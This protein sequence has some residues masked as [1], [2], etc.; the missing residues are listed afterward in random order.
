MLT[1]G[2][3]KEK[4]ET[5]IQSI[6]GIVRDNK[7]DALRAVNN[8][9]KKAYW[10]IGHY[11]AKFKTSGKYGAGQS[12]K[13]NADI[14]NALSVKYNEISGRFFLA[15]LEKYYNKYPEWEDVPP[16]LFWGHL[17]LLLS[18]EDEKEYEFYANL[19]IHNGWTHRDLRKNLKNSYY[20]QVVISGK[21][22][23]KV[24]KYKLETVLKDYHTEKFLGLIDKPKTTGYDIKAGLMRNI[25]KLLMESD[26][27]F[28]LAGQNFQVNIYNDTKMLDY[29]YY[30]RF[31]KC[32]I[33]M[34][35]TIGDISYQD[36][37]Q[38]NLVLS[39]FSKEMNSEG[40]NLP[41]GI[42]LGAQKDEL[43][44]EF[45]IGELR[46]SKFYEN[47]HRYLPTKP[48]SMKI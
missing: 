27:G 6:E 33:I 37:A 9:I 25:N 16:A 19:C 44:L 8:N 17:E 3:N 40:D 23:E 42:I 28:C 26:N 18:I 46:K 48:F 1:S 5:L 4:F 24:K 39:H 31:L 32:F 38:M 12:A 7:T 43:L 20:Q 36:I 29:V 2:V 10:E 21:H 14:S 11:I 15:L 41:I 34:K 47:Y 35:L 13:I 30:N 45:A 22:P